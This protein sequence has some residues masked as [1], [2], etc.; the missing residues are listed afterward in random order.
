MGPSE[1][2]SGKN[3]CFYQA[4]VCAMEIMG[5]YPSYCR[6]GQGGERLDAG[7]NVSSGRWWPGT[8]IGGGDGRR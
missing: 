7:K 8:Q 2:T 6:A 3:D 4:L 1:W 5:F